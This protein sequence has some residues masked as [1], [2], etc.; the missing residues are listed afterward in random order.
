MARESFEDEEI[1]TLLNEHFFPLKV[2]REEHP[3]IDAVYLLACQ[4]ATGHG[5]WPLTILA[6]PD[7]RP[8]FVATYLPKEGN[9][10]RLGLKEV[11]WKAAQ[12]WKE[13]RD[14]LERSAQEITRLLKEVN[15]F[16]PARIDK[17]T[18]LQQAQ[19]ELSRLYDPQYGG[20]GTAPKFPLPL[21]LLFLLRYGKQTNAS[22]I[23]EMVHHTLLRMRYAGIFDQVG[24][25]F[26]RYAVDRAWKVPHF[27]KMLYDQALLLYL[28]TEAAKVL[29]DPRLGQ[30]VEELISYLEERLKAS[31]RGFF[32]AESA[33]SQGQ[34][35]LF[36]T[37]A[38]EELAQLLEGDEW[39]LAQEYFDLRP[40]GNFLEEGSGRP[41]GRNILH[42]VEFPWLFAKKR[43]REDFEK[44]LGGLLKKLKRA[45]TRIPF[46]ARDEKLLTDWNGLLLAGLAKAAQELG[47]ETPLTLAQ[48]TFA[49]FWDK[50]RL[51]GRLLH[52]AGD[53]RFP[54]L[55]EDYV[56]LAWGALEL[57][58]ATG[59]PFY[60]KALSWLLEQTK[61]LFSGPGGLFKQVGRDQELM[62]VEFIPIYEGA[63]PAAN[64][65]LAYLF[66]E[67]GQEEKAQKILYSLGRELQR[68]PSSFPSLLL[69][70]YD[71]RT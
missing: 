61:N 27:E 1:A 38:W 21:R 26:H 8:F 60:Q 2:D 46:P 53:Q 9:E 54:G 3:E 50:A 6:F 12:L 52:V 40:E 71:P 63:L 68:S 39:A 34:E 45:R 20:F 57:H 51:Q 43:G 24:Y 29:G 37:W 15:F 66:Q 13:K 7:G 59:E 58:R 36:Y 11:L 10:H 56:C 70:S 48:E 47:L 22:Q 19:G 55:L 69:A 49:L 42:P 28:Y 62:L 16:R 30:V 67:T 65:L 33:E 32:A 35:G 4:I 14:V 18:V 17:D 64:G 31:G 44:R 41:T 5:G 23:L 25:G